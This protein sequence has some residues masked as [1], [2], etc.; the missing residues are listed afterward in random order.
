MLTKKQSEL[1]LFIHERLKADAVAPSYEE[2]KD[3]LGLHSK[4][5]IHFLV[6]GRQNI[7]PAGRRLPD[8]LPGRHTINSK[9]RSRHRSSAFL[10]FG[11]I[12][13]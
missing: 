9:R 8:P 2:M 6:R 3:A 7:R 10:I 13:A 11:L 1:L 4:S 5:G 12:W